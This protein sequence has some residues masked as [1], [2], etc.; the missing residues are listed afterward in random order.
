MNVFKPGRQYWHVKDEK[1]QRYK[2]VASNLNRHETDI[3]T[4]I[5]Y[6]FRLFK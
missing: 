3:I 2:R 5:D 4:I 1:N 6:I